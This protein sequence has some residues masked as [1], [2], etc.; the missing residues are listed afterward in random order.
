[1]ALLTGVCVYCLG[2]FLCERLG[3]IFDVSSDVVDSFL[4]DISVLLSMLLSMG[5]PCTFAP[6]PSPKLARLGLR[7]GRHAMGKFKH[8]RTLRNGLMHH[9]VHVPSEDLTFASTVEMLFSP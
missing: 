4:R 9:R 7:L 5:I 3:K 2:R 8:F 6:T 1:M